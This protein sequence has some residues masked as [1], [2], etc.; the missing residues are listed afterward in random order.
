MEPGTQLGAYE[1][2]RKLGEGGMGAVYEA[3]H[4]LIGRH[5]AVK[6][7][8]PSYSQDQA[9]VS[10]FF[11]EARAATAVADPG[12]V[13][14][15]DF[16]YHSDG[17]AYLVMEYLEG[18]PLDL[19]LRRVGRLAPLDVARIGRQVATALSAAHKR[20]IVH[21]DLKPE[22]VFLV[23]DPEVMG[24][25][26]AKVLDFGIAKL[27]SD[28]PTR[29]AT[30][31]GAVIGTPEYMSPEQCRG[32]GSVQIDH[33]ADIYALGCILFALATGRPP[34]QGEGVGDLIVAHITQQPVPPSAFAPVPPEL[35]AI[36]MRCLAKNPA[37]RF[38]SMTDLAQALATVAQNATGPVARIE[39]YTSAP[40]PIE[41]A[42]RVTPGTITGGAAE[43]QPSSPRRRRTI[44]IAS[45]AAAAVAIGMT[46]ILLVGGARTQDKPA[47]APPVAVP[48]APPPP[49]DA[50][51]AAPIDATVVA[52]PTPDAA[53]PT[54]DAAP[55]AKHVTHH[56]K[57]PD[58]KPACPPD[59]I[60]CVE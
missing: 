23:L 12:I 11:N 43:L 14:I 29:P 59:D 19:R 41:M 7:L 25:E 55:P 20:G 4:T 28:D 35:D 56:D 58:K 49:S 54:P 24:G 34:F 17:S 33:R 13:Q 15:F 38:Q 51:A 21:R 10:R 5:A 26:R 3:R 50:A 1:I 31:T 22:N 60:Y 36:V 48:E 9:I 16:G 39:P 27:A 52:T 45:T 6:V 53:P 2:L 42:P 32:A 8:L 37:D 47:A 18:E 44:V 57:K 40:T 46:V 30:R